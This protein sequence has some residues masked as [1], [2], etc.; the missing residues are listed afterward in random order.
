MAT[1]A[2]L[3]NAATTTRDAVGGVPARF[4]FVG[5]ILS[6]S[7]QKRDAGVGTLKAS[8]RRADG[9]LAGESSTQPYGLVVVATTR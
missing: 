7:L 2:G 3:G 9:S 8:I 5:T 1:S 6:C 4:E